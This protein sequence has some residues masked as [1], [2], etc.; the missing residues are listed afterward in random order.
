MGI[1]VNR[2]E[3]KATFPRPDERPPATMSLVSK[4][5]RMLVLVLVLTALAATACGGNGEDTAATATV[6]T[7]TTAT[8]AAEE[9]TD[10]VTI[11]TDDGDVE[12][13]VEVE[14]ADTADERQVGLMN[15]ESLPDDAG[16]LFLFQ[17]DMTSG[18]WM[19]NTLIPLSIAFADADGEIVRILDMDPCEADPC[20]IYEPE[21]TYRM[22]LEVNQGAFA[23]W[24]VSE[25]DRLTLEG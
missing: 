1:R 8:G 14:I 22:A 23:E 4:C 21:A 6:E 10:T 19:K 5:A 13:E 25:G 7:A 24:G 20:P 17:E 9:E 2:V 11:E 18:F 15:R 3:L 16:M 12:V